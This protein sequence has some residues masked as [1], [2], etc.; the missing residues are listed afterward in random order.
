ME[1]K[2][3]K[4]EVKQEEEKTQNIAHGD[5]CCPG[6]RGGVGRVVQSYAPAG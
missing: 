6:D 5:H 1:L 4:E 2:T 3:I